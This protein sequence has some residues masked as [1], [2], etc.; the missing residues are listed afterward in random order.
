MTIVFKPTARSSI[1]KA[2]IRD[3]RN[4]AGMM[5]GLLTLAEELG[6]VE[7]LQTLQ[8]EEEERL[9][10]LKAEAGK[11]S[12][13]FAGKTSEME[14]AIRNA[15]DVLRQVTHD[16]EAQQAV[17]AARQ[18]EAGRVVEVAR[19]EAAA[20]IASAQEQGRAAVAAEIEKIKAKL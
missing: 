18:D 7:D 20:I 19:R 1:A 4:L 14:R 17:L 8:R 16:V 11:L 13:E 2:A 3:I 12:E 15:G 10:A 9:A 6:D 5:R